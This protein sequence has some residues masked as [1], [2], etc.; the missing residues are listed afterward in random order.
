MDLLDLLE[1]TLPGLGYEFVDMER[2]NHGKL[3]RVF[4]DKTDGISVD[5][6]ALVS[7]HLS[8][9]FE[10]EGI[11]YDRLEVSSP[12]LDRPLRKLSDFQRFEGERASVRMNMALDGQRNFVGILRGADTKTVKMEIDGTLVSLEMADIRKARLI[13]EI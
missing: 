10:V 3:L 12:G 1:R 6:C 4:I 5:D 9:L 8:H 11:D 13:P 7:N 2:S